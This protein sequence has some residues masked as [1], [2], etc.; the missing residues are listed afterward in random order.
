MKKH[1]PWLWFDADGTLLDYTRAEPI[2]LEQ[3]FLSEGLPFTDDVLELYRGINRRLWQALE[4]R[5]IT[6]S[7]LAVR[8]FELLFDAL[9]L[10]H[11]PTRMSAAF[12]GQLALRAELIDGAYDVLSTLRATSRLAIVTNGL[13]S[14]QRSR[15]AR[16]SIRDFI[17]ELIISEEA[18]A[19]KPEPAFFEAA[20][21]RMG[22]P[23]KKDILLIGDSLASD[24][25]GAVAYGLDTCWYNPA[26]EPRPADLPVTYEIAHLSE[27]LEIIG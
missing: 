24:I 9:G 13:Q 15:L 19:P 17:S 2:A 20:S 11:S 7:V 27:L 22:Y 6:P 8:R 25:Q 1:Y 21:A 23:D 18:G 16:S 3:T 4:K 5:E 26:G 14:V 10:S 12:M